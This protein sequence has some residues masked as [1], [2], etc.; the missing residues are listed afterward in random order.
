MLL[1]TLSIENFR[2]I[3][4]LV[5]ELDRTTVLIGENNTGKTSVLEALHTCMSR[6][7]TRRATPLSE[8]DFH[9][10]TKEA[11]PADAPQLLLTLTFEETKKDEWADDCSSVSHGYP[12]PRRRQTTDYIPS[13]CEPALRFDQI[14]PQVGVE[15]WPD[16]TPK[17]PSRST[18][19]QRHGVV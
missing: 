16:D 9:L 6:G 11:N 4:S 5:L 2:G 1:K 8:Y 12:G 17:F 7:L 19:L 3:A 15:P 14:S 10:A 13:D 18:A